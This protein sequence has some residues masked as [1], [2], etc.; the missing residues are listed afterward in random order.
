MANTPIYQ[1]QRM[2]HDLAKEKGF[3]DGRAHNDPT[4]DACRLMKMVAELAEAYEEVK[5]GDVSYFRR[6]ENDRPEGLGIELADV[7][8]FLCDFCES[9]GI[10]LEKMVEIKHEYNKK[11]ARMHGKVL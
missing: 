7:F 1:W 11:R 3:Y 9:K 6:G 5:T 8:L 10:D 4:W 2:A